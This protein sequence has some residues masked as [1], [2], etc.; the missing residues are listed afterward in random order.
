MGSTPARVTIQI[1]LARRATFIC[2]LFSWREVSPVR[3]SHVVGA[4]RKVSS[5]YF[6]EATPDASNFASQN[7]DLPPGSPA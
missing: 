6:S 1:K 3:G 2:I 7:Y 5:I 4:E